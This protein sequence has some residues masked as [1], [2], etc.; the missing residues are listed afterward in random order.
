[1]VNGRPTKRRKRQGSGISGMSDKGDLDTIHGNS[2]VLD[3]TPPEL[4]LAEWRD[5]AELAG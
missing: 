3:L 4:V 5:Q 2:G 1:M